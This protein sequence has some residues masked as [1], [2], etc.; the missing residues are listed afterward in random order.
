MVFNL[1]QF[2]TLLD[3]SQFV[4]SMLFISEELCMWS[5]LCVSSPFVK[6]C[7]FHNLFLHAGEVAPLKLSP[8]SLILFYIMKN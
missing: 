1:I 3:R 7:K 8:S 5:Y 4:Q 2:L 6:L